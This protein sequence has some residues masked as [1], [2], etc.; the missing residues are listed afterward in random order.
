M[1]C[2]HR[3]S[4]FTFSIIDPEIQFSSCTQSCLDLVTVTLRSDVIV[5]KFQAL[6]VKESLVEVQLWNLL[7][8]LY[9]KLNN[10]KLGNVTKVIMYIKYVLL[11]PQ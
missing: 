11:I 9:E 10:D 6:G 1:S 5:G 2:L 7:V 3:T 4:D 8:F